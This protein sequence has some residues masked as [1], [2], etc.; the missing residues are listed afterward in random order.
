[1]LP[2]WLPKWR[3]TKRAPTNFDTRGND[4]RVIV[5]T[6]GEMRKRRTARQQPEAPR[7]VLHAPP[8]PPP[9]MGDKPEPEAER[10]ERGVAVIDFYV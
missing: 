6:L 5:V 3:Q 8:P 2:P 7:P 1:M 9:E 4:K 10:P